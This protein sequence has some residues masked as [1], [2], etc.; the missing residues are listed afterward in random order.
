VVCGAP[1]Y[2][3]KNGVPTIPAELRNHR[4]IA[5]TSAWALPEWRFAGDQRVTIDA[6]LRCNSNDAA[7]A[8]AIAGHGLT[9]VLHY[10]IGPAVLSGD[11]RIILADHEEAPLPIHILYPDGQHAPAKL[12]LFVELAV[13]RLRGNRLL[14]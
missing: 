7:I 6:F 13:A 4:V 14:N 3:A 9:R 10:Q 12:R 5:S 2:F 11:L 8:T 1:K